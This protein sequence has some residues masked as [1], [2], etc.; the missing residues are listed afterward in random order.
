MDNRVKLINQ[1]NSAFLT[2]NEKQTRN[3]EKKGKG[4]EVSREGKQIKKA[5]SEAFASPDVP[6]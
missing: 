2:R 5:A 6:K 3:G 4:R 1:L